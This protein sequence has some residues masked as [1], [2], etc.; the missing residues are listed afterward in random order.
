MFLFLNNN[1]ALC[2]VFFL[3]CFLAFGC[4]RQGAAGISHFELADLCL[5]CARCGW[6]CATSVGRDAATAAGGGG[7]G[8]LSVHVG[9]GCGR[10]R[11]FHV[12]SDRLGWQLVVSGGLFEDQ[13]SVGGGWGVEGGEVQIR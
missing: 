2:S 12:G 7:G 9:V 3:F 1:P 10:V 5:A 6:D 8:G 13:V 11:C 4:P